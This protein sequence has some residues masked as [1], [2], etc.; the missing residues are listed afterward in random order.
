VPGG[1]HGPLSTEGGPRL[2][3]TLVIRT[4]PDGMEADKAGD[5]AEGAIEAVTLAAKYAALA[6]VMLAAST[7]AV[8]GSME[9]LLAAYPAA[10]L[11]PAAPDWSSNDLPK[12]EPVRYVSSEVLVVSTTGTYGGV[13]V[14][15]TLLRY[16]NGEI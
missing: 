8:S 1:V 7:P 14:P 12:P 13:R 6:A 3:H 10:A 11:Q 2:N 5:L 9:D 15:M 16:R 4:Y